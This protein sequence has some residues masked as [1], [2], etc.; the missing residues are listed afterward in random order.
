MLQDLLIDIQKKAFDFFQDYTNFN[1]STTGYGL[2]SDQ[3]AYPER[4][5]IAATGFTLSSYVIGVEYGYITRE[6]AIEKIQKTLHSLA[7]STN[8]VFGFYSHFMHRTTGER[9]GKS[10][11]STIDTALAINGILT[12]DAYF[13]DPLIT[14]LAF[15]I[16]DRVQ[17][18]EL[19][20]QKDGK[21]RYYMAYNPDKDGDYAGGK[22]GF[23]HHWGMFAEQLMMY[24]IHAGSSN[25]T[26]A[27][28]AYLDFDRIYGSYG[29][30]RYIYTP[31]NTLFVYQFPLAWLDLKDYVDEQGI[32]WFD[33]ARCAALSHRMLAVKLQRK[34]Q[35]FHKNAW[36][37][38][39]CDSPNGYKVFHA[40]P[41][42]S[43]TLYTDGT[44]APHGIIGS[45]P[46]TPKESTEA[47]LSMYKEPGLYSDYGF[48]DAFNFEK[49]RWISKRYIAIDKG[50]EMLMVNA[51]L[52]KD[53]QN[54]YMQHP[55]I[56]QGMRV[57]NWKKKED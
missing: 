6:E 36:G 49:E 29:P 7:Y 20:H 21:T 46:L 17:W 2:T 33:N 50:L 43:N 41:N 48:L 38:N 16:I 1:E 31:G 28:S 40:L 30:Y 12:V 34:Y 47:I 53:V 14:E 24:V 54:A 3:S 25:P 10:E 45:L 15:L 22:P 37:L 27:K 39:A 57:L 11:Y 4:A 8:H 51:Y 32:S 42:S 19:I 23:I 18:Q 26:G 44:I 5:S 9:Y 13:K 55:V 56:Q 35:T 52:T